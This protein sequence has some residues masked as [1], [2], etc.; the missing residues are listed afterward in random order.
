MQTYPLGTLVVC[1]FAFAARE[2][3]SGELQTFRAA[4]GSLPNGAGIDPAKVLF[5]FKP[6]GAPRKT[7]AGVLVGRIAP[8]EYVAGV[9]G[10]VA[11]L[12]SYRGRGEDTQGTPLVATPD[13]AFR[14]ARSF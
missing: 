3:S 11:G 10:D 6:P 4:T 8:G 14:I 12:W 9:L 1:R 5:D 13:A 2:L 7:W